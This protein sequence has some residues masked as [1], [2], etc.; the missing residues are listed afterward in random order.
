[1]GI[2]LMDLRI[3]K[4][5]RGENEK[6]GERERQKEIDKHIFRMKVFHQNFKT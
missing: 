1:M 3:L 6:K 2:H 5:S 4:H